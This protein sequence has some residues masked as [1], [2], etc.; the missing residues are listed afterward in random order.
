MSDNG[1]LLDAAIALN[2]KIKMIDDIK[3]A[4]VDK[5]DPINSFLENDVSALSLVAS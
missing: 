1:S 2:M 3:V 5:D 4:I